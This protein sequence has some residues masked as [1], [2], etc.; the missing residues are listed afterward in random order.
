M[1]EMFVILL[2]ASGQMVEMHANKTWET[3]AA[4]EAE[5]DAQKLVVEKMISNK[6]IKIK[7]F[8]CRTKD[9]PA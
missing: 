1:I 5:M 7:E 8:G 2:A 3:M 6:P 9:N 4:C